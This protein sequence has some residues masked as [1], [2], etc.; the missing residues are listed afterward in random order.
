[1]TIGAGLD[2]CIS[3]HIE[4]LAPHVGISILSDRYDQSENKFDRDSIDMKKIWSL[5]HQRIVWTIGAAVLAGVAAHPVLGL[6]LKALGWLH[7]DSLHAWLL[8][9]GHNMGPLGA[10]GGLGAAAA[11]AAAASSPPPAK[12]KD[13]DPLC[14]TGGGC[15]Q[16]FGDRRYAQG[17]APVS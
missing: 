12:D 16:S 9:V 13:P 4:C 11:A 2:P 5:L 14:I 15:T 6:V 10:A 1:M 7:G 3:R 8:D 17:S